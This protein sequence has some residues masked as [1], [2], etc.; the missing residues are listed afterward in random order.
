MKRQK[1]T[2]LTPSVMSGF[3]ILTVAS[4]FGSGARVRAAG[5]CHE[6]R[7]RSRFLQAGRR[8]HIE[9]VHLVGI[10]VED[11]L[12]EPLGIRGKTVT[13]R[14]ERGSRRRADAAHQRQCA[15]EGEP[16]PTLVGS[17]AFYDAEAVIEHCIVEGPVLRA[18]IVS[19]LGRFVAREGPLF[20]PVSPGDVDPAPLHK[21]AGEANPGGLAFERGAREF[22]IEQV[23]Q[24]VERGL[25]AA[26][27]R[28]GQ[29][30][31]VPLPI[32]GQS[33]QQL[34]AL[35]AALMRA[36]AG[37]RLVDHDELWAGPGERLATPVR[38]DVVEADDG[39]GMRIEQRLRG[40]SPRSSRGAEEA[41]TAAAS[42]VELG[43]QFAGP[44]LNQMRRAEDCEAVGLA[45]IDQLAQ[46]QPRLDGLADTDIVGDQQPHDGQPQG[47]QQR[48][49]LVGARLECHASG[50]PE[51]AGAAP[52]RQSQGLGQQP[53]TILRRQL[54]EVRHFET[55]VPHRLAARAQDAGIARRLRYR[56]VA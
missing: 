2:G 53:G 23:E 45:A 38:L 12:F 56:R 17:G 3:R 21:V 46:D 32:L 52:E 7:E 36:D 55:S 6:A 16:S 39:V 42:E 30:E 40:G 51:R 18:Q 24:A 19:T 8:L 9:C 50:R 33:L 4:S 37:M 11:L 41:V 1:T 34:E 15:P 20:T 28:R 29:Q 35:L 48:Y 26:V 31:K 43:V 54:L 49:Q 10:V 14:D 5:P 44:L 22:V 47:H 27:R 25:V 13:K